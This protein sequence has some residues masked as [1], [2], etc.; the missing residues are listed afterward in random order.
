MNTKSQLINVKVIDIDT[1]EEMVMSP[2]RLPKPLRDWR[3]YRIEYGGPNEECL[4][5]G[6]VLLPKSANPD[7]IVQLILGMQVYDQLWQTPD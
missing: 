4:W 3:Y 2:E 7:A 6:S 1:T 5:E